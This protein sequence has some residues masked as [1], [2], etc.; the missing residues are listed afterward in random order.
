MINLK[1]ADSAINAY[2]SKLDDSDMA[3]LR[4]FRK[5][6]GI[7]DEIVAQQREKNAYDVPSSDEISELGHNRQPVFEAHPVSVNAQD[8]AEACSRMA[9]CIADD[10]T[11]PEGIESALKRTQWD[12]LIAASDMSKAGSHP[13]E[14]L[15][16]IRG[17]L[18]DDGMDERGAQ[19][20]ASAVSLALRALLEWPADEIMK[21][22]GKREDLEEVHPLACPVCGSQAAIAR[23]GASTETQGG[24]KTLWCGQCGTVWDYDRIRCARCG[25]HNQSH[26]HYYHIE[27][28]DAHRIN[29]CDECGNYI[30]T[31][32]QE[33]VLVPSCYEVEDIVM[34]PLDL[35]AYRQAVAQAAE[36]KKKE[37]A[38]KEQG[39]QA[40]E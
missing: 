29:T 25:T 21:V 8:L 16:E 39:E 15:E 38:E 7:E 24:A 37:Q 2:A 33:D 17:L 3:R 1:L 26:L 9:Q 30:R 27:G 13:A 11:F 36:A 34:A 31:V 19:A 32:F 28:D 22:R 12:R 40:A 23:V 35:V 4:F 18:V 5:L 20:G 10:G 6:W 14:Y